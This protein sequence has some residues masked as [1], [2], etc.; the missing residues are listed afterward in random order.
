VGVCAPD[1][2]GISDP[3][4][5]EIDDIAATQSQ[6]VSDSTISEPATVSQASMFWEPTQQVTPGPLDA[7]HSVSLST[8]EE[9]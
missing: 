2:G 6:P 8:D 1:D 9:T 5:F 3:D 7:G 4:A